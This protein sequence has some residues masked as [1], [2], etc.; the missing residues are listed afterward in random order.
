MHDINAIIARNNRPVLKEWREAVQDKNWAKARA[1]EDA[2]RD[3]F[4]DVATF[5]G[6]TE[7]VRWL[8]DVA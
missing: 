2:N 5:S 1:I 3:L 4:P 7:V 6:H 8:A